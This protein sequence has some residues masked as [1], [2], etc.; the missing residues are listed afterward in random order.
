MKVFKAILKIVFLMF[1]VMSF[2]FARVDY[3]FDAVAREYYTENSHYVDI[4]IQSLEGNAIPLQIHYQEFQPTQQTTIVLIHGAFSSSHTFLKW[5]S[6]LSDYRVI[7][8]DLPNHGLSSLYPDNVTSLR[9]QSDVIKE[10]IDH[11]GLTSFYIGGNSMGGGASWFFS[12]M[13]ETLYDIQGIVLIDAISESYL[14]IM[15][16]QNL[17]GLPKPLVS[18]FSKWTPRFLFEFTLSGVYGSK[19]EADKATVDRYHTLIRREGIRE[20]IL[21][22]TWET[23]EEVDFLNIIKEAN[24][25]VL[26]MWGSEDIVVPVTVVDEFEEALPQA[27]TV[28]YEGLGHEPHAE[29]PELTIKDLIEFIS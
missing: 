17:S 19:V 25:P 13:Y 9:R 2:L 15:A 1:I 3:S 28:I 18:L 24:I 11:L 16:S 14:N 7:L 22:T 20:A 10:V 5:V 29:D 12:A 6:Y 23:Y 27:I 4:R 8:I 21:L 26:I